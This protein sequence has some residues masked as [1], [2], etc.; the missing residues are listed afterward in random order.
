MQLNYSLLKALLEIKSP[1]GEE[2]LMKKFILDYLGSRPDLFEKVEII[3]GPHIQDCLIIRIGK[4]RVAY[5]AH[6]DTVGFT[7]RYENQ[8]VPIG[9]PDVEDRVII[10]GNDS[11]GVI[12][13]EVM[14][15]YKGFLHHNFGRAIDRGTSL[16][17]KSDYL[18]N[19]TSITT[20]YLDN[21]IGLFLSLSLL[22]SMENG[23]IVFSC[24]EEIGGGSIPYLARIIYEEYHVDQVIIAD[25]TWSTDGVIPE[26]GTVI[27][28]RDRSIPRKPFVKTLITIAD[29]EKIPYQL[30]V[31]G[32]GSSDGGEIQRSL[33]PINWGFIGP[34]VENTHSAH[35][36]VNKKDIISTFKIYQAL[37]RK[38]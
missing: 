25:V 19:S 11:M 5:I 18:E 14:P 12:E 17:Y 38:L 1:S 22:D 28:L 7:A 8:L 10:T 33:Y 21:R 29:S 20:P 26:K 6:M 27:S 13:C 30:E 31:E 15:N 24:W 23:L 37:A 36:K 34:P 32:E 35:E 16:V 3:E 2:F 9:S 4:P